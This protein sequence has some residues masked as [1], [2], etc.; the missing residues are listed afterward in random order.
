MSVETRRHL[1]ARASAA[2][3][4]VLAGLYVWLAFWYLPRGIYWSP[5]IGLK[6]IQAENVRLDPWLD[7]T[8]EYPGQRLDPEFK[9]VPFR[10]SFY[11]VWQDRIHFAQPPGIAVLSLP[12][13]AWL[14]D[15]G[16]PV[17]PVLSGLACLFLIAHLMRAVEARLAWAGVLL[18]GLATPLLIYS[19]F[20]WEHILAVAL[21]LGAITLVLPGPLTPW[22]GV[23]SGILL[24]TAASVRKEMMLMA[25]VLG[26]MLWLEVMRAKGDARP[27]A[28]RCLTLWMTAGLVPLGL[29]AVY[30]YVNSGH[31]IPPE[32]RISVIPEVSPRSY[33]LTIGPRGLAD[34]IFD[35]AFGWRGDLLVLA[36]G[37]YGLA[38]LGPRTWAREAIQV[39]ALA[40]LG[41]GTWVALPEALGQ[42]GSLLG[43]LSVS[44]FLVV[45]V[46]AHLDTARPWLYLTLG[47]YAL[48][49][50]GLGFFTPAGPYQ[51]GLEWGTRFALLVFPLGVPLVV[52]SLQ[53]VW[54]RAARAWLARLHVALALV[55]IALSVLIQLLGV[56]RTAQPAVTVAARAELLGLDEQQIVTNLWWL[57]AA[58]PRLYLSREVFLI[59][60]DDELRAWLHTAHSTSRFAFVGQVRLSPS[61]LA[62]IAPPGIRVSVVETR[63][64]SNQM[65]VTRVEL[66][67]AP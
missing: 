23:L 27:R 49:I 30:A 66:S 54:A 51:T 63:H 22:R 18:A 2:A 62:S 17:V 44:P 10:R 25:L 60:S 55:L 11:Y 19:L 64:L 42:G 21:A 35:P 24:G 41:V 52:A 9:F 4:G 1:H 57:T 40:A 47:Y 8:I 37:A 45:G 34:F 56:S 6:R 53:A 43:L 32:F 7:L 12:F 36:A 46:A 39:G 58:A 29:Y 65:F 26:V 14:G 15:L 33:L 13:V 50:V 48:V 28:R 5:D 3:L 16:E 31:P 59:N 20:L 61:T 38:N 67:P